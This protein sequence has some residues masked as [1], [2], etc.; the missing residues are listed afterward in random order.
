MTYIKHNGS[1]IEAE[2][3]VEWLS[4]EFNK[5]DAADDL[6][7][8]I[9]DAIS[10][11]S[12]IDKA[13]FVAVLLNDMDTIIGLIDVGADYRMFDDLVLVYAASEGHTE[14]VK[15]LVASGCDPRCYRNASML[16][17]LMNSHYETVQICLELGCLVTSEA[18]S[19]TV[20]T[21]NMSMFECLLE[22]FRMQDD[23]S[24]DIQNVPYLGTFEDICHSTKKCALYK[25]LVVAGTNANIEMF[26]VLMDELNDNLPDEIIGVLLAS[27]Q[28]RVVVELLKRGTNLIPGY[29][30]ISDIPY[31]AAY[32]GIFWLVKKLIKAGDMEAMN[33]YN[34]Y[35]LRV[36]LYYGHIRDIEDMILH[37]A[38][39][40][41]PLDAFIR[42]RAVIM[43]SRIVFNSLDTD[44]ARILLVTYPEYGAILRNKK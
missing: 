13:F 15:F 6:Q 19:H 22:R 12:D 5:S 11:M 25:P 20:K 26:C 35:I 43:S 30:C 39:L 44:M 38:R 37:G 7:M 1:L 40:H 16:G 34:S 2:K 24:T 23:N 14:L 29:K 3:L 10:K 42:Y 28:S 8:Y 31:L 41:D 32:Y 4:T 27:R 36:A 9:P 33:R 18:L 17:A 21:K